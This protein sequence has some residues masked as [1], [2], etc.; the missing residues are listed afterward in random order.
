MIEWIIAFS[1]II[2]NVLLIVKHFYIGIEENFYFVMDELVEGCI[3]CMC[4]VMMGVTVFG[5][6]LP[7]FGVF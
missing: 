1:L 6:V 7:V 2:I 5:I 4:W 3:G